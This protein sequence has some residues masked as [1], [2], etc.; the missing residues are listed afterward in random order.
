[1]SKLV[2]F[3]GYIRMCKQL[4]IKQPVDFKEFTELDYERIKRKLKA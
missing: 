3:K 2:L 1:M 4:G